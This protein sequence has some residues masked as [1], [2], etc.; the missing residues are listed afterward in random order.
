MTSPPGSWAA[1]QP[2]HLP[3][4]GH[5]AIVVGTAIL[6]AIIVLEALAALA[7]ATSWARRR[8]DSPQNESALRQGDYPT[9]DLS[10]NK[11]PTQSAGN[12]PTRRRAA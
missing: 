9:A 11:D 5:T 3:H 7:T 1:V 12:Q 2:V 8:V 10:A 4:Y 6:L